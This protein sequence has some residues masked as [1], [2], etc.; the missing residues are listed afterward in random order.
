MSLNKTPV[1]VLV[2]RNGMANTQVVENVKRKTLDPVIIKNVYHDSKIVTD[3]WP[4]NRGTRKHFQ[5]G[6][7]FVNDGS[8]ECVR[9]DVYTNTGESFFALL[10]RGIVG[11]CHH[12][13][14]EHTHRYCNEFAFRWNHR[15]ISDS[16]RMVAA[17]KRVGGTRLMYRDSQEKD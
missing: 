14:K 11:S 6:H 16:E 12:I 2:E 13:S 4:S 8:G 7:E 17:I 10:N 1:M 5:G 15:K 3:E 9:G